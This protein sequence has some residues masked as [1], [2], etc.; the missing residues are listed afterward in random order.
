MSAGS[1]S[2]GPLS[3]QRACTLNRAPAARHPPPAQALRCM[4]ACGIAHGDVKMANIMHMGDGSAPVPK[5]D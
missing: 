1:L 4:H 3:A 2:A 5:V